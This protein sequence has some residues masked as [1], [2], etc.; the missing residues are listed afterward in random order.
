[1]QWSARSTRHAPSTAPPLPQA[2]LFG[3]TAAAVAFFIFSNVRRWA[4][5]ARAQ[6]LAAGAAGYSSDWA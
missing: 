3:A 5:E 2:L 4:R 6:R 1:M